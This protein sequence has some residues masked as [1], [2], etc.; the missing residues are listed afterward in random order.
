MFIVHQAFI[1][2]FTDLRT[3]QNLMMKSA[4]CS[5]YLPSNFSLN[6]CFPS[7]SAACLVGNAHRF[8]DRC[9]QSWPGYRHWTVW[10]KI[11]STEALQVQNT[12][13]QFSSVGLP[14]E[15]VSRDLY[16]LV[17][18]SLTIVFPPSDRKRFYPGTGSLYSWRRTILQ[19]WLT[20]D[21]GAWEAQPA[22]FLD[23][24]T[25]IVAVKFI[26]THI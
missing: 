14:K 12:Y 23:L 26:T 19:D 10:C 13:P 18:L 24:Q 5:V 16:L 21:D 15:V 22:K 25:Y 11:S 8:C 20:M 1:R 17:I 6:F 7:R 3:Q 4:T 2:L 9:W